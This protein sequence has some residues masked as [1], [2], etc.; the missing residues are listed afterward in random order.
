M[1]IEVRYTTLGLNSLNMVPAAG[2]KA[3]RV[4][5]Y[6]EPYHPTSSMEA[7][8]VAILGTATDIIVVSI[9]TNNVPNAS[10]SRIVTSFKPE[11]YCITGA[12]VFFFMIEI[13]KSPTH[14]VDSGRGLRDSNLLSTT[15]LAITHDE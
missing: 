15:V 3:V 14:E 6:A 8:S 2:C 1:V 4:S 9:A 11:G 13:G 5:K 7:N 10:E 12:T